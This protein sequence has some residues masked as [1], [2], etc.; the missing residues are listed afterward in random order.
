MRKYIFV[1]LFSFISFCFSKTLEPIPVDQAFSFTATARDDQTILAMWQIKPGY[2]LYRDRLYFKVLKPADDIIGEPLLPDT[3]ETKDYP[4]VG[5]MKVYSGELRIPI[6]VIRR[7]ENNIVIQAHYQGCSQGGFCYPPV[8]KIISIDLSGHYMQPVQPIDVD[9]AIPMAKKRLLTTAPPSP[10]E[11]IATLLEGHS[12]LAIIF[13]FLGFGILISLTP[14]VLPMIPILSGIIIGQGKISHARSFALSL[15]Y[16]LGMALTYA[17]VGAAFAAA[18]ATVQAYLQQPWIIVLF[19][20][21]FVAMALSLFGFYAI[22]LPE[23]LR[24]KI[25]VL[26]QHQKSSSLIGV[27]IMGVLSTLILSPCVTAPLV[28]VLSYISQTGNATLGAAALFFMGLGMGVPL[29]IVGLSSAKLLPKAGKWMNVTKYIM[30]VLMLAVAIWMLSRVLS[31]TVTLL[32]WAAL[33]MGSAIAMGALSTAKTISHK[34]SK[35]L[36]LVLFIYGI[37]LVVSAI[38]GNTDPF[39]PISFSAN[40]TVRDSELPFIKVKTVNEV[41]TQIKRATRLGKP[42]MLDFYARWCMACLE[43]DQHAFRDPVVRRALDH[44]VLL[45][46]DVTQNDMADKALEQHFNVIAPPTILF[47]DPQGKENLSARLVGEQSAK[48]FA[49]HLRQLDKTATPSAHPSGQ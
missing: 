25:A 16:V 20:L 10:Q 21:I 29:L 34:I 24:S 15:A 30:G 32:L 19:S 4:G 6:P 9:V 33:M 42:V 36:G 14:C 41:N 8:D 46:A 13:S 44:Y 11:K 40:H 31:G 12:L 17:L 23:K 28:G 47:F 48:A 45:R 35:A 7:T 38:Q 43:M 49:D 3:N 27:F 2:Y 39:K 37:L 18:G 22:Q 5:I 26:S 1:I